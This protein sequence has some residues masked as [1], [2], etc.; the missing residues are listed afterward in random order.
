[1]NSNLAGS[2]AVI[3]PCYEAGDLLKEALASA[4]AQTID[5]EVIICDDGSTGAETRIVLDKVAAAGDPRVTILRLDRNRGVSAAR[6]HAVASTQNEY[7]LFLD[8]DDKMDPRYA[9]EAVA[10]LADQPEVLIVSS[11]LQ[12]FGVCDRL[13]R[14]GGAPRG[15][16]D[17]LFENKI[18]GSSVIRREDWSRVGGFDESVRWAEDYDLWVRILAGGGTAIELPKPRYFYRQHASQVTRTMD[19]ADIDARQLELVTRN[20]EV[21]ADH[22]VDIMA[23]HLQIQRQL[24]HYR[25]R[26]GRLEDAK[27]R[28]V[29][30]VRRLGAKLWR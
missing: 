3:I 1:M 9:Q 11:P 10:I 20:V 24:R 16:V 13:I 15:V 18:P 30:L 4:L 12:C 26:Y 27:A 25:S 2:V 22:A 8:A 6:N 21:W 7:I 28:S 23:R 29:D 17:V 14:Y 19:Q 5:V